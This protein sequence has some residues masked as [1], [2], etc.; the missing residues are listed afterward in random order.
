[1]S[2]GVVRPGGGAALNLPG[3]GEAHVGEFV[4]PLQLTVQKSA[5]PA[6]AVRF[7]GLREGGGGAHVWNKS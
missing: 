3:E 7:V 2:E 6:V 5:L 4:E 1:V